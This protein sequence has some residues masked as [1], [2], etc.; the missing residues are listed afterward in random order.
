MANAT[1]AKASKPGFKSD[2][3]EKLLNII[4]RMRSQGVSSYVPLPQIIVVGDQ[5]VL[6]EAV[7]FCLADCCDQII[8]Q[9][10]LSRSYLQR[11]VPD[12]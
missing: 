4:D 8:G 6:L 1:E 11:Q 12:W 3:L 9:K 7:P 2:G 5:Q 10:Q